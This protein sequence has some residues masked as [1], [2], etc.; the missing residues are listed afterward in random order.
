MNAVDL[1]AG[2][3]G[4]TEAARQ[5]G[6]RVMWAAHHWPLAV[7]F[8]QRNHPEVEH[9]CQDLQQADWRQVP[10]M[11]LLLASPACQ[12]HSW[13]ATRG[14]NGTRGS[15]PGHD[16]MR[17]TAWAIVSCLEVH[18]APVAIVENTIG[19]LEWVLY[20]AWVTALEALGY[21][22]GVNKIDAADAGVPQNRV[23][24][25]FTI[26]KGR[27]PLVLRARDKLDPLPI[28]GF[29]D[30]DG[31]GRW[32]PVASKTPGTQ[33]RVAKGRSNFPSGP[34]L[35]QHVTGHPGR[36]LDRPI[37]TVT[38]KSQWA[39]VREGPNGD[40]MRMLSVAEALRAQTFPENY[41]VPENSSDALQLIGNAVPV[42]LGRWVIEAVRA[43]A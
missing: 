16:A 12:G 41:R 18:R 21:A 38:T 6:V 2:L 29:L 35:T 36:S 26:A 5:A 25:F 34:F 24:L 19:F 9:S 32:K 37:G 15:A 27:S 33:V 3:G 31:T 39:L 23:R 13:A 22:V 8:H 14:G 28:R 43:A 7:E 42:K 17:S 20:P 11:D 10:A 4:F 40:E 1:F 30:F